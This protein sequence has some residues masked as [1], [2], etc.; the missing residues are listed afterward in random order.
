MNPQAPNIDGH[1][2]HHTLHHSHSHGEDCG[3]VRTD[4]LHAHKDPSSRGQEV[5]E[6]EH[7]RGH[8]N[9]EEGGSRLWEGCG[10]HNRRVHSSRRQAEV[11]GDPATA[12][13][14][15]EDSSH[16]EG[17]EDHGDRSSHRSD[18]A[19]SVDDSY[20]HLAV[21]LGSGTSLACSQSLFWM[22]YV[23]GAVDR[24]SLKFTAV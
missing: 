2:R 8:H 3:D 21:R 10:V 19:A 20:G 1:S 17:V 11:V 14:S 13:D 5:E 7:R 12:R 15:L 16:E 22:A 4:L 6:G 18:E 9:G 23:W 24:G